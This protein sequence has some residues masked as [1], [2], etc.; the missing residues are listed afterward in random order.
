MLK[1]FFLTAI[2]NLLRNKLFTAINILGLSIATGVFLSLIS[3]VQYH[4]SFDRFYSDAERIYRIDYYEFQEGQAVLQSARTHD[5][6]ALVVHDYIPEFE[7][8]ARAYYEKAYVWNEN[9]RLVDQDVLFADSSFLKIFKLDLISGSDQSLVPPLAVMI[10]RSQ[11]EVY[12]GKEDPMGKT[13]FM[14]ERLPF[15]VTGVVEDIPANSSIDFDFLLS[16]STMPYYGW[17]TKDGEFTTPWAFTFVKVKP[18]SD[19]SSINTRLE[20]LASEHITTLKNRGHSAKYVMHPYTDLHK[21]TTLSSEIKPGINTTLLYALI[22]L[23]VFILIA[24]W[25]NYVNLSLARSLDRAD[26]IGV[27]KLPYSYWRAISP[28]SINNFYNYFCPW[29]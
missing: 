29:V 21:S 5:R 27:R 11:A 26:E 15:V 7:A 22:S 10:S 19:I 14:N 28:G 1:H 12:F 20:K 18:S 6:T 24:A 3:Y 13:L 25:I 9:I 4:F 17:I 8:V 23:G 2:R 16:W